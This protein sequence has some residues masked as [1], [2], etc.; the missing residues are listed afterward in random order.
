MLGDS[1]DS[2]LDA[3][4]AIT[5][6]DTYEKQMCIQF[7]LDEKTVT[8]GAMAKGSGMIHPNMATMLSFVSTDVSITPALLNKALSASTE[9]SYNMISVDGD[10][11]TNDMVTVMASGLAGNK[12]IDE[13]ND[14]FQIFS[15][16]LNVLNVAVAKSIVKDGEGATKFIEVQVDKASTVSD[17]RIMARAVVSSNLVKAAFFGEDANWGRI[18]CAMGYSGA[19]FDP[20]EVSIAM[21]SAG[22]QLPLMV[23]GSPV[24]LDEALGKLVLAEKQIVVNISLKSGNCSGTAWGLRSQL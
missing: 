5:T 14:D 15:N 20:A 21:C 24:E 10:T 22:G 16:A 19:K 13:E 17:A 9:G 1:Y 4:I 18:I 11:S 8:I 6:T 23:D 2:G 7:Q 12:V 3:A